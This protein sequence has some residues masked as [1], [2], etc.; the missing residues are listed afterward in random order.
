MQARTI[1][2]LRYCRKIIDCE[3]MLFFSY[4]PMPESDVPFRVIRIP[5]LNWQKWNEFVNREVPKHIQSLYAMS[6]HED[7]FPTHIEL[8]DNAFLA[9]DYI[10]APWHDGVVG[11]GGFNIESQRLLRVK[12][13]I[14]DWNEKNTPSDVW[15]CRSHRKQ[16]EDLGMKFAPVDVALKFSTEELDNDR[17]SYGFHGRK[18]NQD[19]YRQGWKIIES[20]GC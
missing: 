3:R 9:Y 4:L 7:G 18:A 17:P 16:L 11:N 15:V 12:Q 10:G 13:Q 8:W 20:L 6:V 2:V 14:P 19:K 1:R 5:Q